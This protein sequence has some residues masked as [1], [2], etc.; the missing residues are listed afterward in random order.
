MAAYA[1]VSCGKCHVKRTIT[2]ER[3]V[4]KA[5]KRDIGD[6]TD[7]KCSKCSGPTTLTER[8]TTQV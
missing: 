2:D 5:W 6:E 1:V 7:I 3:A 8:G 4:E